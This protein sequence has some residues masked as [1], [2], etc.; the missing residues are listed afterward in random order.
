MHP[1]SNPGQQARQLGVHENTPEE[2]AAATITVACL[3]ARAYGNPARDTAA[4]SIA[5]HDARQV[6]AAL[7]LDGAEI[8]ERRR[9]SGFG[10]RTVPRLP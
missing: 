7:G 9:A 3:A 6:A 5:V 2:L 4:H 1:P 8:R 10:R